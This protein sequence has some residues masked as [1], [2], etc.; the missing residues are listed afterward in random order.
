[1]NRKKLLRFAAALLC[2]CTCL[3]TS[4]LAVDLNDERFKDKT[5]ETVME[6]FF[7]AHNADASMITAGYYNTVTE[8][9]H[10]H[11]KDQ[12]MYG[13]SVTKLPTNML[14]AERVYNGEMTMDTKIR[15]NRYS[16]LQQLSL[17][18]SDNPAMETMIND[19]GHG[20]YTAFK[21]Q[22][23]PY[24]G[25]TSEHETEKFLTRNYLSAGHVMHA[26][27]LLYADPDRYPGVLS[28]LKKA[29]PG[30]FFEG[31]PS[32]Y[33]IAHKYGWFVTDGIQYLND[34]AIVFAEDPFL[35]VM[36]TGTGRN[37]SEEGRTLLADYCTL[38][39]DY[40]LYHRTLRYTE[41]AAETIDL[42]FPTELTYL[43]GKSEISTPEGYAT[44]QFAF[45]GVGC[46]VLIMGLVLLIKK[47]LIA[48]IAIALSFGLI[49]VGVAPTELAIRAIESGAAT[50]TV[51]ELSDRLSDTDR[52]ADLLSYG[53]EGYNPEAETELAQTILDKVADSFKI[54]PG[55]A[56]RYGNY[57]AIPVT[58]TKVDLTAVAAELEQQWN[59]AFDSVMQEA[60][61]AD[62]FDA[63]GVP[64]DSFINTARQTALDAV[65]EQWDTFLVTEDATLHLTLTLDGWKI[66]TE[67]VLLHLINYA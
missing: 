40:T 22:I 28:C 54:V 36:F 19:L 58:A 55:K 8:E 61:A 29:T 66:L 39:S 26:L 21:R 59:T 23:L 53:S 57:I 24:L 37:S 33:D 56:V 10:F 7:A 64:N 35:I 27:K 45:M 14:Y 32:D 62:L 38:M 3:C 31:N 41:H 44:W 48:L 43:T 63:E 42:S 25:T 17:I 16:M 6:E 51:T 46:A 18:N 2:M 9:E 5:W 1:M 12:L 30:E 11:N 15:G 4:V 67:E 50:K 34:S 65:L 52:G 20:N 13:A 49:V 47:K 60:A